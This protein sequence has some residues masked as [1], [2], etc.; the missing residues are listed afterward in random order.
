MNIISFEFFLF[1]LFALVLYYIVPKKKQW[2]VLLLFSAYFIYC[3]NEIV[4]CA[5]FSGMVL[6]TYCTGILIEKSENKRGWI[7]FAGISINIAAWIYFKET[8]LFT[9]NF[10]MISKLAGAEIRLD[11]IRVLAPIGISYYT[12]SLTGYLV[13]VYWG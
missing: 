8:D 4:L 1:I 3:G 2:T 9:I 12:F 6:A 7:L 10:N 13:D 5:V 11:P